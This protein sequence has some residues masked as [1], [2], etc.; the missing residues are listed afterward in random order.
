MAF[1]AGGREMILCG[2]PPKD[3]VK[4][5]G[6]K[7]GVWERASVQSWSDPLSLVQTHSQ[8]TPALRAAPCSRVL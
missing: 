6:W 2:F 8:K 3:A 7:R 1:W 5:S 4:A